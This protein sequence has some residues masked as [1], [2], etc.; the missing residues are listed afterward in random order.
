MPAELSR[1]EQSLFSQEDVLTPIRVVSPSI[2]VRLQM[3]P[4]L[5]L[6]FVFLLLVLRP[7]GLGGI[8]LREVAF[9]IIQSLRMLMNDIGSNSVEEGSV[10]GSAR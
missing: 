8:E 9:V 3:L 6:R 7:F 10:V 4:V 2:D 5:Q 1:H